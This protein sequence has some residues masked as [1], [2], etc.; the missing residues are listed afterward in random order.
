MKGQPYRIAAY[1]ICKPH[2][3]KIRTKYV[4][5]KDKILTHTR[6]TDERSLMQH[7]QTM[8]IAKHLHVRRLKYHH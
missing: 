5:Y 3:M 1:F 4:V 8:V 2:G 6:M 7:F